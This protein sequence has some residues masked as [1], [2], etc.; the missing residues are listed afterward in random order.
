MILEELEDL[1]R[2]A[3]VRAVMSDYVVGCIGRKI[4]VEIFHA[5][6]IM[7]V[8]VYGIDKEILEFSCERNLCPLIDA[9]ITY[10]KTD[11][12]PL[13]HSSRLIVIDD[14]CNAMREKIS[15]LHGKRI[16]FYDDNRE[17][18]IAILEE[19]Y[20]RR[21]NAEKLFSVREELERIHSRIKSLTNDELQ[22]FILEYY[23]NFLDLHERMNFLD[24]LQDKDIRLSHE[25]VET[26]YHCPECRGKFLREGLNYGRLSCNV[27]ISGNGR[28][29]T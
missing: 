23:I 14:T 19:V 17:K 28:E 16:H 22:G 5:F 1:R 12:C 15:G 8:P 3:Y 9:T 6:G 27:G 18:L 24:S 26:I 11:K 25:F 29:N 4:P 21:F 13:I 20:D 2:M 10:A 7:S